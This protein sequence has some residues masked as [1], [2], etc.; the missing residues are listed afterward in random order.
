MAKSIRDISTSKILPAVPKR[1]MSS[2]N[3]KKAYPIRG[4]LKRYTFLQKAVMNSAIFPITR[5]TL[6]TVMT[7]NSVSWVL[8]SPFMILPSF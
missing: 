2:K 6:S 5:I 7:S 1:N 4:Y 8:F 3:T